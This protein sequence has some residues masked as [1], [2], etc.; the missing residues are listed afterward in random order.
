MRK[1]FYLH[2]DG[3]GSMGE[4]VKN[5]SHAAGGNSIL[6]ASCGGI[7]PKDQNVMV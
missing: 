3:K 5:F 1:A 7:K 4:S 2:Y 6:F